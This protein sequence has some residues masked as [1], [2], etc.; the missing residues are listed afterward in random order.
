MLRCDRR[1]RTLGASRLASTTTRSLAAVDSSALL[2]VPPA[3]LHQGV[4][5]HPPTLPTR[6]PRGGHPFSPP[7]RVGSFCDRH[8]G[9]QECK[10]VEPYGTPLRHTFDQIYIYIYATHN[11]T[12]GASRPP[13]LAR[14]I[15][16]EDSSEAVRMSARVTGLCCHAMPLAA[17]QRSLLRN[18]ATGRRIAGAIDS[19]NCRAVVDGDRGREGKGRGHAVCV[20]DPADTCDEFFGWVREASVWSSGGRGLD[21]RYGTLPRVNRGGLFGF[22]QA[23]PNFKV[24]SARFQTAPAATNSPLDSEDDEYGRTFLS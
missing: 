16:V 5:K 8:A 15:R 22:S 13:P 23:R 9:D 18:R 20:W 10:N 7:Y 11:A 12:K 6:G 19:G 3:C 17:V 21:A 1:W 4:P 2:P 24:S 14:D